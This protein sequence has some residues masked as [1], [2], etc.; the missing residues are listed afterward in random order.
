MKENKIPFELNFSLV[1]S[2]DIN[3]MLDNYL[4]EG[5]D[6]H[7]KYDKN[8][9]L[10]ISIEHNPTHNK[11]VNTSTI[12]NPSSYCLDVPKIK[13]LPTTINVW[14]I[15]QRT[16]LDTN[17]KIAAT[18]GNPLVYA[19]KNEKNYVFKSTYDKNTIQSLMDQILDKFVKQWFSSVHED[20]ATIVCPSG[21]ALNDFFA[22]AFKKVAEGNGKKVILYDDVLTKSTA[23][24]VK[25]YV[26]DDPNSELNRWLFSLSDAKANDVKRKLDRSFDRMEK[27]HR[28]MFSYHFIEDP[29][30]RN[31]I[32][33]SMSICLESHADIDGK[34]VL[35]LDD[36]ISRGK[37]L[38]E[39]YQLICSSYNPKS[40]TALTLFSP[41]KR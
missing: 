41:L 8:G 2:I 28:G 5:I 27:E 39:A 10:Q 23:D 25:D 19:M 31:M 18:D 15:F 26:L 9:K 14:S 35:L 34:H 32:G 38:Q 6:L 40:V 21:N 3:E 29:T 24:D 7:P 11:G 1:D 20:I 37:T 17:A 22:K 33:K 4:L 12:D 16:K 13:T 30:I 36:T